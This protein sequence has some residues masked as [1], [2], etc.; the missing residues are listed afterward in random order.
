M[1][2]LFPGDFYIFC[3]VLI[4]TVFGLSKFFFEFFDLFED[5]RIDEVLNWLTGDPI[6]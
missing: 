4:F 2:F 3:T 1:F 5:D 6:P